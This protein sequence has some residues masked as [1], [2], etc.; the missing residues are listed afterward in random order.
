MALTKID[1]SLVGLWIST[2]LVT[3]AWK[4]VV[5]AEE[6]HTLSGSATTTTRRTKTC[7]ALR[8]VG[9][10]GWTMTGA[11]V[12]NTT[13]TATEVS[14]DDLLVLA[15]GATPVL[16][17]MQSAT[18]TGVYY[19]QGKGTFSAYSEDAPEGDALGF[20]YTIEIDGNLTIVAP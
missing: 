2:N 20:D 13:P 18:G 17:K 8:S 4:E 12:A 10:D 6:S 15:Q 11:G 7:G 16:V 3:P 5:C 14:A 19:R 1:G 9:F